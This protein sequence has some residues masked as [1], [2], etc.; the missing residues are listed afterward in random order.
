MCV[1]NIA[2]KPDERKLLCRP[3][4]ARADDIK[5]EYSRRNYEGVDRAKYKVCVQNT[6]AKHEEHK[7]LCRRRHRRENVIKINLR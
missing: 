4:R 5:E 6:A 7:L 2:Q 1:Q 3:R